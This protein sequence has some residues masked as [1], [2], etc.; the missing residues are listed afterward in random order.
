MADQEKL[1]SDAEMRQLDR[2]KASGKKR[3]NIFKNLGK[4]PGKIIESKKKKDLPPPL[5]KIDVDGR[6][7]YYYDTL[8]EYIIHSA[9]RKYD[10]PHLIGITSCNKGEGVTTVAMNFAITLARHGDGRILLVDA[11]VESPEIHK[12]LKIDRTPGLEEVLWEGENFATAI[13]T[14]AEPNLWVL[15]AGKKSKRTP[16]IFEMG[17]FKELLKFVKEA[18][19]FV[20]FDVPSM[21]AG[22]FAGQ[23]GAS[24]DGIMIIVEA[25]ITRY[26]VVRTTKSQLEH[27]NANILGVVLNKRQFHV[28]RWL[29]DKI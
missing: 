26:Q 4:I 21:R 19:T 16:H 25:E 18:Y 1:F 9:E 15:P 29:Y 10:I 11:N 14:T 2:K 24:I 6:G 17:E 5:P 28:P 23:L 7:K 27:F 13:Q 12:V 3:K 20:I 22:N 8:R